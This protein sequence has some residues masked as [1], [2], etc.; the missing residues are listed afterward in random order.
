MR[1]LGLFSDDAGIFSEQRDSHR[2]F[3]RPL[4]TPSIEIIKHSSVRFE[5]KIMSISAG[6]WPLQRSRFIVHSA[7]FA[8]AGEWV[9]QTNKLE[10]EAKSVHAGSMR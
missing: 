9:R 6:F 4:A 8:R 7:S 5:V 3:T 1:D 2:C 10:D